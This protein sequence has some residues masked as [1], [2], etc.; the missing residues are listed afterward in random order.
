MY[1][2]PSMC[3]INTNIWGREVLSKNPRPPLMLIICKLIRNPCPLY[4][5]TCFVGF[6]LGVIVPLLI[7]LHPFFK[8]K[9]PVHYFI[10]FI[11]CYKRPESSSGHL[12]DDSKL[13]SLFLTKRDS[14]WGLFN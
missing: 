2:S 7:I 4:L 13:A 3:A 9:V 11:F 6:K 1:H 10:L 14:I 8:N 12:V 5:T